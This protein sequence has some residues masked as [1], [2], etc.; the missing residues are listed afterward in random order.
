MVKMQ[1]YNVIFFTRAGIPLLKFDF[2]GAKFTVDEALIGGFLAA[3]TGFSNEIFQVTSDV[4]V[5]DNG[6]YK[7]TILLN[8]ELVFTVI[9]DSPLL[10]L[11]PGLRKVI[12][13]FQKFL[14]VSQNQQ[15]DPDR[16]YS[17]RIKIIRV[18]FH[19]P[20]NEE[21]RVI[22]DMQSP[23]FF[24]LNKKY[25]RLR[26]FQPDI[27]ILEHSFYKKAFADDIFEMLNFAFYE[28]ICKF[29]GI[30]EMGDYI[31]PLDN[32]TTLLNPTNAFS[33]IITQKVHSI[34][35]PLLIVS[36]YGIKK[37]ADLSREFGNDAIIALQLLH[38]F[39]FI[40]FV[41]AR[42]RPVYLVVDM[43]NS[44]LSEIYSAA[45]TNKIAPIIKT[46]IFEHYSGEILSL[47]QPN[48]EILSI[49]KDLIRLDNKSE[50]ELEEL[51]N[52]LNKLFINLFENGCKILGRNS[53]KILGTFI[54]RVEIN[55]E[56]GP[57]VDWLKDKTAVFI[58]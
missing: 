54:D 52:E 49:S 8:E 44:L 31:Y 26:E 41:E 13:Y 38:N 20:I 43:I 16:L 34:D 51:K 5:V 35:I 3:I 45:D 56:D 28:K 11:S 33:S 42:F 19:H 23:K 29:E 47:F 2:E 15:Y 37:I 6:S 9:S 48:K 39:R 1:I 17:L 24:E 57:L 25:P 53:K 58:K 27:K 46:Y 21:W 10:H 30:F 18:L 14:F 36:I 7:L 50:R 12:D 32:I 55:K 22:V 40:Q 4:F